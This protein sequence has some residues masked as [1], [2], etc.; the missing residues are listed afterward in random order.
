MMFAYGFA[1]R[2]LIAGT[3]IAVV[4]SLISFFVVV[5]RLAFAGMGISHAAFGGVALGLAA[6]IDPLLSAGGFCVLIA[7]GIGWFSRKGKIHEDTVIGILFASAMA[8][9]VVLVRLANA[10][11]LDLMSYL[12][13]S[14]LAMKWLDVMIVGIVAIL[15]LSFITIFFKELLFLSFDEETATASGLPVKFIYYGLLIVMAL[16]IVVAIKLVGI[17]LVS[18]LLVIPGATAS[19][20]SSNYRGVLAWSLTTGVASV[21]AGLYLSFHFDVAS[22]AAIVLVLFA[23]FLISMALS[24]RRRYM[25]RKLHQHVLRGS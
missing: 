7:L 22:G 18:A 15:A 4:C 10:Y 1:Q 24:P 20:L 2:A 5:R 17:V 9:G 16:T 12:F 8:L 14:I 25:K 13:G 6:G 3:I 23:V 19:Q 11:N 21:F